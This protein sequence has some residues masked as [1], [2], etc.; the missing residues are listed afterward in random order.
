MAHY[1][2]ISPLAISLKA[3]AQCALRKLNKYYFPPGYTSV[4]AIATAMDPRA[5]L[6]WW[7]S[8]GWEPE[9][10]KQAKDHVSEAWRY[11]RP[12]SQP[13]DQ[14]TNPGFHPIYQTV[15]DDGYDELESYAEGR[16]SP[17]RPDFDELTYC[18]WC[19][20]VVS[21]PCQN[22][23][24]Y[25]S[26]CATSTPDERCFSYA[27]LFVPHLR[28][29]LSPQALKETCF[30]HLGERFLKTRKGYNKPFGNYKMIGFCDCCKCF[31]GRIKAFE[32]GFGLVGFGFGLIRNPTISTIS[33]KISLV[34]TVNAQHH[35]IDG[36]DSSTCT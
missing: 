1:P 7:N 36:M 23:K 16:P 26:V 21:S 28:N 29:R 24:E 13:R 9:A 10:A 18:Q 6:S 4:Y 12:E 25:L 34:L 15:N 11:F 2:D 27:K 30:L 5:K 22:G 35:V 20:R 8:V 17:D 3:G 33:K 19:G 32:F 31:P 14:F